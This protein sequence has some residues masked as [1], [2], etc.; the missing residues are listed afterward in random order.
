[1]HAEILIFLSWYF[2]RGL[3]NANAIPVEKQLEEV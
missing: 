3:V 1:M 2:N